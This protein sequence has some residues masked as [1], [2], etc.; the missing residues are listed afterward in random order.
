M[1]LVPVA[2]VASLGSL[3]V[4]ASIA[5][6]GQYNRFLV[7]GRL[8]IVLGLGLLVATTIA[9]KH[10]RARNTLEFLGV[11]PIATGNQIISSVSM[12]AIMT[13][14]DPKDLAACTGLASGMLTDQLNGFHPKAHSSQ[15]LNR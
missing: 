11:L 5:R 3:V 12:V 13:I 15:Y 8:F 7:A 9:P 10:S 14:R 6:S 4:G 2:L 1:H